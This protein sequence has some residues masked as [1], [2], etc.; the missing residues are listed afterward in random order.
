MKL[1]ARNIATSAGAGS[2]QI[3]K[4]AQ[5]MIEEKNISLNRAKELLD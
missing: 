5:E 2:S 4:I 3:D 1:H